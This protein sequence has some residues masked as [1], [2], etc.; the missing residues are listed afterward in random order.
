MDKRV[1]YI[2]I[3]VT[4]SILILSIIFIGLFGKSA[5]LT[6]DDF[7]ISK[8]KV[9][10]FLNFSIG[11][12]DYIID[13]EEELDAF[14]TIYSNDG[15]IDRDKLDG[16]NTAFVKI[17]Q[18][19]DNGVSYNIS[20]IKYMSEYIDLDVSEEGNYNPSSKMVLWYL[21]AIVP[22]DKISEQKLNLWNRPSDV[23]AKHKPEE[24]KDFKLEGNNYKFV[25]PNSIRPD[26][27]VT[28]IYNINLDDNTV[29]KV[30]EKSEEQDGEI[31]SYDKTVYYSKLIKE[32]INS[33]ITTI[34]NTISKTIDANDTE[35][36]DY[37]QIIGEN[38]NRRV[39][40]SK[41]QNSIMYILDRID[42]LD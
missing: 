1:S 29:S 7:T 3:I 35:T 19:P 25:L 24:F 20:D 32:D 18:S 37:I 26:E 28:Y 14:Y 6:I 36:N 30:A 2:G 21:V 8:T 9:E 38:I 39:Y 16:S 34:I 17:I 42:N 23:L 4:S 31:S 41:I 27:V 5:E 13:S 11:A 40:D 15:I 10:R 22:S 12:N 33:D